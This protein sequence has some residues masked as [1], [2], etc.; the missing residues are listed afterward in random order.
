MILQPIAASLRHSPMSPRFPV[1]QISSRCVAKLHP[2]IAAGG[3]A[4]AVGNPAVDGIAGTI[5][6]IATRTISMRRL[7][8]IAVWLCAAQAA[9]GDCPDFRVNEN[10]TVPFA[11][12]GCPQNALEKE[13]FAEAAQGRLTRLSPLDAALVAG[14]VEDENLLRR[15]RDKA[16]ALADELRRSPKLTGEPRQR[17]AVAFE[18]L[19][20]RI[21]RGGYDLACTDLRRVL[22]E[23]RFNCISATVLFNYLA[24]ALGLDCRGLEMPGHAMSRVLLPAGALDV[25]TTCPQWFSTG[26]SNAA[27]PPGAPSPERADALCLHASSSGAAASSDRQADRSKA[28]EVTPS[29]M[30]AMI[31]YNRGV[32]LLA[33]RR[34]A[35]A[36]V[37]NAKALRLDPHNA[38]ARGNLLATINN[39]SIE[40]GNTGHFAEAVDLLRQGLALDPRF[41][42]FGQN[43]V[44]I[45]HQWVERLCQEGRFQESL[46]LLSR[47]AAEMPDR[48]Y[49]RQA[50]DEIRKHWSKAN[51]VAQPASSSTI[52][53]SGFAQPTTL[54][55]PTS[56]RNFQPPCVKSTMPVD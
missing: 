49:L 24:G 5:D 10:G 31:Y 30:A 43:Y 42:A 40:L 7:L 9:A 1:A 17:A 20:E 53:S 12:P 56:S 52:S 16:A 3:H 38:T 8:V 46:A 19:H 51:G 47:A 54:I 2:I 55:Q 50:Q 13:L 6:T 32:D 26:R 27:V 37:A 35:E 22:D 44:H 28:R 23:G 33:E 45:H 48:D 4:F 21:L 41:E 14:G 34:F 36:A 18:F 39:W 29:Q 15:Y 11:L 25:E